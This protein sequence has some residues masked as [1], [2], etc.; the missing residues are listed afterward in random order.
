MVD[1]SL[2]V[3][4]TRSESLITVSKPFLVI[5]TFSSIFLSEGGS[6]KP[7]LSL[8][9]CPSPTAAKT[10]SITNGSVSRLGTGLVPL[11][12]R[13]IDGYISSSEL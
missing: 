13:E 9:C 2:A 7:N 11:T 8:G 12:G 4:K 3:S 5:T 6:G 1:S 10:E